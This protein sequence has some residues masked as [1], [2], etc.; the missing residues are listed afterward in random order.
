MLLGVLILEILV[1]SDSHRSTANIYKAIKKNKNIKMVIHLGDLVKDILEVENK[2]PDLEFHYVRGNNDWVSNVSNFK[3][4]NVM[5]KRILIT[6]GHDYG[7]KYSYQRIVNK[8]KVLNV[9]AVFFGHTH[10][11]EEFYSEKIM[12]LNPGS[13]GDSRVTT[14]TTYTIVKIDNNKMGAYFNWV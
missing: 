13:I 11:A 12:F 14:Y 1:C 5:S 10:Q 3:I 4:L 2:N 8:G 9:D 7:V 6:H